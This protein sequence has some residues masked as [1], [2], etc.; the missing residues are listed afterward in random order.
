MA[1]RAGLDRR[2]CREVHMSTRKALGF[3]L[4]LAALVALIGR[5]LIGQTASPLA[6]RLDPP[7][8]GLVTLAPGQNLR[9]NVVNTSRPL[10]RLPPDPCRVF[11]TFVDAAG[12]TV[13]DAPIA[14]LSPGQSMSADA[15]PFSTE[16]SRGFLR[17]RPVVQIDTDPLR[18]LA[19]ALPPDPCVPTLEVFDAVTGKTTLF[20]DGA[21]R[22]QTLS[23]IAV[24]P[25]IER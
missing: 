10:P 15:I 19:R 11:V 6:T 2:G 3:V 18:R 14:D 16:G 7:G 23:A 20:M 5:P 25:P 9:L 13:S 12:A 22:A 24:T 4:T 17:L 1:G 8:F 21:G